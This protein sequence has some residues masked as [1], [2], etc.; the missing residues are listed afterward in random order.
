M[1]KYLNQPMADLA[2]E[3]ASG[4]ARLRKGYV[5]AA[6]TLAA[7]LD[8][9]SE[10]PYEF[11]VFRLTGYRLPASVA[12][13]QSLSGR[14]LHKDL[15][16]LMQ[17]L[18][19]SFALKTAEYLEPIFDIPALCRRFNVSSKTVQRWMLAGL[20]G[21][22]LVFPDGRRRVAFLQSSVDVFVRSR[23]TQIHRSTRFTQMSESE[24]ADILRRA[25]RLVEAGRCS[26]SEVARR[27]SASTG[28]AVETIRYT[29]RRHDA[30][31]PQ[32]AIFAVPTLLDEPKRQSIYQEYLQGEPAPRLARQHSRTRGSI[33]RILSEKRAGQ[34]FQRPIQY[35]YNHQF[36]LP[37]ADE[38]ILADTLDSPTL[39]AAKGPQAPADLPPYLQSLYEVPLLDAQREKD[40]FRRYN[41]LK[42][43]ADMLRKRLDP[44]AVRTSDVKAAETLLLEA[45]RIK[46][47]MVRANLRLVVS[48]AKKHMG[49]PMTLFELISDGNISLLKAVEKFDYSRGYRF[50]TYAS[51]A[52]MRNFARSVPRERYQLDHFSTGHDEVVDLA[53]SLRSYDPDKMNLPELRESLDMVLSRLSPTERAIL[54]NHYGLADQTG[55]VKT[56]D[57]L[58]QNLGISKERVR[59]I[60]M[61]ALGKLRAILQGRQNELMA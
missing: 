12:A 3:L 6:E 26:L 22:R 58:G 28:R 55:S 25:K 27:L 39:G 42:Y 56:L 34:L 50:S 40:L 35:L 20:P 8:I 45:N 30:Q 16:T 49:G 31:C 60:E 48:I 15:L 29:I 46:N 9:S 13:P 2:K 4:L 33:Y 24:R 52:I 57:Q 17:D 1:R 21:R 36:D 23:Q 5:D 59:Q 37:N 14:T 32:E 7:I 53:S 43:K 44:K 18:C 51:W 47:E 38:I 41:Y 61:R 54:V 10:Y 19:D 11:V